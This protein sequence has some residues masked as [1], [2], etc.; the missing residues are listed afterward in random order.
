MLG[1]GCWD[2]L[3]GCWLLVA[4][5]VGCGELGAKTLKAK[6]SSYMNGQINYINYL[7][8]D[9]CIFFQST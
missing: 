5:V 3:L 9:S 1:V 8:T 2:L 6:T 7:R 4:S